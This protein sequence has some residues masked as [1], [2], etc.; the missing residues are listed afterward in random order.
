MIFISM[1]SITLLIQRLISLFTKGAKLKTGK[2][3]AKDLTYVKQLKT[4]TNWQYTNPAFY[5][6]WLAFPKYSQITYLRQIKQG[7][8]TM[9]QLEKEIQAYEDIIAPA[10]MNFT[11]KHGIKFSAEELLAIDNAAILIQTTL[12]NKQTMLKFPN[13]FDVI[14][15][16]EFTI[17]SADA[18]AKLGQGFT[19]N[20]QQYQNIKQFPGGE[21]F[22][23]ARITMHVVPYER[24][25]KIAP[26]ITKYW[27]GWAPSSASN[28]EFYLVAEQFSLTA[29]WTLSNQL[30]E[31][32]RLMTH[33]TAHLKDPATVASPKL[34]SNYASN[35]PMIRDPIIALAKKTATNWKKNYYYHEFEVAAN[36]GPVLKS[37]TS[38]TQ[39]ILRSAGKKQTLAALD[40]LSQWAALGTVYNTWTILSRKL[41]P[42][43]TYIL[44]GTQSGSFSSNIGI[45][46]FFDQFKQENPAEYKKVI[47]K[48]ARQIESL[49]QQVKDTKNLTPESVIKLKTLI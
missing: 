34:R 14:M 27:K 16:G 7:K 37:I 36:L 12:N 39:T 19:R 17:R 21:A 6:T 2:V 25:K 29:T 28:T 49:K 33:E 40:E 44:T 9:S 23:Q 46:R 10:K 48:L 30:A 47:N 41:G 24:A 15:N 32:K 26:S 31:I 22:R 11:V 42:T 35:A 18:A 13:G 20:N 3:I 38:Q 8:M 1:K 5:K 4:I 43:A 45:V